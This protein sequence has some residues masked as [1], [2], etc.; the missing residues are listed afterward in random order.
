[1]T[2]RGK[3]VATA[4]KNAYRAVSRIHWDGMEYRKDIAHRALER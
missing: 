1:M 2:A 4:V 3:D